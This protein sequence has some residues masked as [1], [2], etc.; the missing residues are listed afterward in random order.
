VEETLRWRNDLLLSDLAVTEFVSVVV[1]P[2]REGSLRSPE[3][4]RLHRRLLRD[5][6]GGEFLRVDAT[7]RGEMARLRCA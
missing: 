2:A 4:R 1:R 7:A 6:A 5:L 3:A